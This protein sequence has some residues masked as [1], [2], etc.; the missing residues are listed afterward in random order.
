MILYFH[1]LRALVAGSGRR[2][3]IPVAV[4]SVLALSAVVVADASAL[5]ITPYAGLDPGKI[6]SAQTSYAQ[7]TT[8][9]QGYANHTECPAITQG[10]TGYS[11]GYTYLS[12]SAC[13]PGY[14]YQPYCGC[15]IYTRGA[16]YNP[17]VSTFDSFS[18]LNWYW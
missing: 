17:N 1:K 4:L 7:Q 10:V 12:Y 2:R 5:D 11:Q 6:W 14:Q 13:G 15:S 9:V 8:A 18:S 3:R 16:S